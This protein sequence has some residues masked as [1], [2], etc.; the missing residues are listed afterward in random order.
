MTETTKIDGR[1]VALHW[2][3]DVADATMAVDTT[4]LQEATAEIE[5]GAGMTH[6]IGVL[7]GWDAD[8]LV[9]KDVVLNTTEHGTV[10]SEK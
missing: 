8:Y 10:L 3:R 2:P 7:A 6:R 1:L 4:K 9:G 5:D